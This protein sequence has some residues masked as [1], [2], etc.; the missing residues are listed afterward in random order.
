MEMKM[1]KPM[2]ESYKMLI[3]GKWVDSSDGKTCKSYCPANGEFLASFPEA[4]QKDVDNAVKAAW[5]AFDSWK[6]LAP[7]SGR[8]FY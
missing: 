3:N 6:K 2:D 8:L 4:T 5:K 7:R 1:P